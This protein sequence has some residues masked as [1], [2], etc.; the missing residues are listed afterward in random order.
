MKNK[1][2]AII[3]II[4]A[5]LGMMTVYADNF[6]TD[7]YSPGSG[8]GSAKAGNGEWGIYHNTGTRYVFRVKNAQGKYDTKSLAELTNR[9]EINNKVLNV[10]IN[11][12]E[13]LCISIR[14]RS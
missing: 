8:G 2:I 1:V 9:E 12:G 13:C 6:E 3:M 14:I 4:L 5:L 11:D 7:T 10:R